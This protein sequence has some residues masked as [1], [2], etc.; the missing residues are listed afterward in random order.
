MPRSECRRPRWRLQRAPEAPAL[1]RCRRRRGRGHLPL[2]V[3]TDRLS[4]ASAATLLPGGVS[5]PA[6]RPPLGPLSDDRCQPRRGEPSIDPASVP[7]QMPH[8]ERPGLMPY[9]EDHGA[10]Q[11]ACSHPLTGASWERQLLPRLDAGYGVKTY[12]RRGFGRSSSPTDGYDYD[13]APTTGA[14]GAPNKRCTAPVRSRLR[15][16]GT[17]VLSSIAFVTGT[18]DRTGGSPL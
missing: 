18:S 9:I 5:S 6:S 3:S 13:S 8:P 2:A 11:P 7:E 12:D 4:S 1:G 10:G 14:P 16:S 17:P 15:R